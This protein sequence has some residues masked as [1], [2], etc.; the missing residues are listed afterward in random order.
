V[1]RGRAKMLAVIGVHDAEIGF[2]E[3]GRLLQHRIERRREIA[4]RA[5]GDLQDLGSRSLPLQS[6]V[7]LGGA[8]VELLLEFRNGLTK[9]GDVEHCGHE[10]VPFCG[11]NRRRSQPG[12]PAIPRVRAP[13]WLRIA[14]RPSAHQQQ[15]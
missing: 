13:G 15:R 10:L 7:A 3:A 5:V 1:K 4:R 8:L 2:A 14:L 6:F 12:A 9:I 11:R